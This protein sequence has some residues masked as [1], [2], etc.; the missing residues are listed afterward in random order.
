MEGRLRVAIDR[1]VGTVKKEYGLTPV[2]DKVI[3]LTPLVN[4]LNQRYGARLPEQFELACRRPAKTSM[5]PDGGALRIKEW[6]Q[7][8]R[9]VLIAEAKRQGTNDLRAKK[10]QD[11]QRSGNA[12]ERMGKNMRGFDA[13]FLG[14]KI[15]PFV[16]FGEG[17]DFKPES[18]IL[19]RVAVLNGF[20]PI[21]RIF[22]HTI[23]IGSETLRP[24]TL[25]FREDAWSPSEMYEVLIDVTEQAI[26][27]Y[28]HR[29]RLP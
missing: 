6:G 12:V 4:Q 23:K 29:Y 27:Y 14:E 1:V 24:T 21:N 16:C 3:Y 26:N 15:T 20:F 11:E 13:L 28:R 25:F 19:D 2:L 17:W 22:V 8:F 10:G 5:K 7:P 9:Y 18:T